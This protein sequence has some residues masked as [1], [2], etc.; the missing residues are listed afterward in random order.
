[1]L[2]PRFRF[3]STQKPLGVCL[4]LFKFIFSV[5]LSALLADEENFFLFFCLL[6]REESE[7]GKF[8]C[9]IKR[10]IGIQN[11][12]VCCERVAFFGSLIRGPLLLLPLHSLRVLVDSNKQEFFIPA[13]YE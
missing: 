3:R 1:M 8:I 12:A 10:L 13:A 4:F 5:K 11:Y 2:K 9:S 6:T 7:R